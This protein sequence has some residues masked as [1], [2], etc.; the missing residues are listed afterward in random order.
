[1]KPARARRVASFRSERNGGAVDPN[2][3]I[4]WFRGGIARGHD[5]RCCR[6]RD[7][8]RTVKGTQTLFFASITLHSEEVLTNPAN[9]KWAADMIS[10]T[11]VP[12]PVTTT[13]HGW[14]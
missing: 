13:A 3:H 8:T 6:W 2:G 12:W 7:V 9:G 5:E 11:C 4:G 1:M 14:F 10:G